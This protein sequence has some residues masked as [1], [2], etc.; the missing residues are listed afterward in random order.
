MKKSNCGGGHRAIHHRTG[1]E[2]Q[3]DP[4]SDPEVVAGV[5][6]ANRRGEEV[7]SLCLVWQRNSQDQ[8]VDVGSTNECCLEVVIRLSQLSGRALL[9]DE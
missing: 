3:S 7:V 6:F 1:A 8:A 2:L 5:R 4:P 9:N